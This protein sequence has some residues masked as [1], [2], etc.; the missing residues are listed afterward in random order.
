MHMNKEDRQL[1]EHSIWM[2]TLMTGE[3]RMRYLSRMWDLY[4]EVFGENFESKKRRGRKSK[5]TIIDQRKAY[6]LCTCLV[7]IFGH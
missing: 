7:K 1:L 4:F 6:D 2:L 5:F 3:D